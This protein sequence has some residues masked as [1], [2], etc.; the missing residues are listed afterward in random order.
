MVNLSS[1]GD[2][3]LLQHK[4]GFFDATEVMYVEFLRVNANKHERI[5][6]LHIL[7]MDPKYL[8]MLHWVIVSNTSIYI[9]IS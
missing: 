4:Q 7:G 8:T 5:K 9:Y 1:G 2:V 6:V 3:I